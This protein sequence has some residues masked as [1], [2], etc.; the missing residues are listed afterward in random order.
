[1]QLQERNTAAWFVNTVA[2]VKMRARTRQAR[3]VLAQLAKYLKV[4]EAGSAD[5]VAY[6]RGPVSLFGINSG[7]LKTE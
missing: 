3:M 7:L 5:A 6:L 1:M 4:C 2:S